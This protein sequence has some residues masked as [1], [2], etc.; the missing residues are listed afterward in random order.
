MDT[1]SGHIYE[2]DKIKTV[3]IKGQVVWWQVGEEVEVKGCRFTVE[4]IETFPDDRIILKG[5]GKLEKM[6]QELGALEEKLPAATP[7][8]EP[9]E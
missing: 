4:K 6:A 5:K 3:S 8:R 7:N 1:G 2:A 9:E